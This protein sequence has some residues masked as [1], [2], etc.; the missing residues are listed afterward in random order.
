[1]KLLVSDYDGTVNFHG[2][3]HKEDVE[4]LSS[5]KKEGNII[6]IASSRPF[7][8]LHA[9]VLENNIPFDLLVCNNGN[10]IFE[11]TRLI[12]QNHLNL[13]ELKALRELLKNLPRGEQLSCDAWGRNSFNPIYYQITLFNNYPFEYLEELFSKNGFATDYYLNSGI[14]FSKTFQKNDAT[15][16]MLSQ[17]GIDDTMAYTIGDGDNDYEMLRDFNG[18]T[19]P[20][21]SQMVRK[22]NLP[23]VNSVSEVV[24]RII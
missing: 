1:M 8:S 5:F 2:E 20:W 11:G 22:L 15:R 24:Q 19:F 10:T 7:K 17:Y 6:S 21:C 14:I 3:V 9:E 13:K 18:Y 4:A 12:Y 16:Y 23:T